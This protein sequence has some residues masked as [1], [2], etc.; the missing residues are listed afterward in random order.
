MK[1][2]EGKRKGKRESK[3]N[4]SKQMTSNSGQRTNS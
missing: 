1:Q 4:K 3:Q 2:H